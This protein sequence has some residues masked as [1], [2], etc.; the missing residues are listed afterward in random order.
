[1]SRHLGLQLSAYVDRRLDAGL[2]RAY[3]QHLVACQVCRHAA[4]QERRLLSSL[5]YGATPGLSE[6]LQSALLGMAASQLPERGTPIPVAPRARQAPVPTVSLTMPGLHRSPRRAAMLAG[7]AATASAA[8]AIGLAVAGPV[9]SASSPTRTG[10]GAVGTATITADTSAVL[11]SRVGSSR[12][13]VTDDDQ[14]G[15]GSGR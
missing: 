8:A 12:P 13:V 6:G 2:L 4:D 14:T 10:G 5:R 3:D 15:G 7:F 1:M 11:I 9:A